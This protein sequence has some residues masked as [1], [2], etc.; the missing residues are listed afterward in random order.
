MIMTRGK[1]E[2]FPYKLLSAPCSAVKDS[3]SGA[4]LSSAV[5]A[6]IALRCSPS[7]AL[8]WGWSLI[9]KVNM[10]QTRRITITTRK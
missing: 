9:L 10:I 7:D 6:K 1:G 3:H 2:G 5:R 4:I 8:V